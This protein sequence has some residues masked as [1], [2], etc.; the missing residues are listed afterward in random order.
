[1]YEFL[2]EQPLVVKFEVTVR[3]LARVT[4]DTGDIAQSV[5]Y[6]THC[7]VKKKKKSTRVVQKNYT[8]TKEYF[9]C[10]SKMEYDVMVDNEELI[11]IKEYLTL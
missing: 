4:Q 8:V 9:V 1:M 7:S 11:R 3:S 10:C 5:G 6:V 2:L